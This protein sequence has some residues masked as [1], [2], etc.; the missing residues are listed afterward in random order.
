MLIILEM[1][2]HKFR[3][4]INTPIGPTAGEILKFFRFTDDMILDDTA[5]EAGF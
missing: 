2:R 1:F 3:E 4:L 5:L